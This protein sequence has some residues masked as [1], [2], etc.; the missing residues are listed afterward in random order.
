[1]PIVPVDLV[2]TSECHTDEQELAR[3]KSCGAF[4]EIIVIPAYPRPN[5]VRKWKKWLDFRTLKKQ[6]TYYN[7]YGDYLYVA[8]CD[9]LLYDLLR[10]ENPQLKAYWLDDGTV[11][12]A[13]STVSLSLKRRMLY[14]VL[15]YYY[16][17]QIDGAYLFAPQMDMLK[18]DYPRI[19]LNNPSHDLQ[20]LDMAEQVWDS[21]A[22]Q[23]I[24]QPVIYFDQPRNAKKREN[25]CY[26]PKIEQRENELL[27]LII[28]TIGANQL[29]YKLHPRTDV[30]TVPNGVRRLSPS[31][32]V[33][34][35]ILRAGPSC[36]I[37]F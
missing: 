25:D 28:E 34:G 2:L 21:S 6:I 33:L 31:G 36:R 23:K 29:G 27:E 35:A 14:S 7:C 8:D 19:R 1:M 18:R 16:L 37:K 9:P 22:E 11:H 26:D 30:A 10:Y 12:I 20:L 32:I 13:G 15:R 17:Q 4:D 5:V 3:L 24:D